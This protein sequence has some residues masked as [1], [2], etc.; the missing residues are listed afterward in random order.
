MWTACARGAVISAS[1]PE[2]IKS[3]S[4]LNWAVTKDAVSSS[5][6]GASFTL[7]FS[8]TR[9]VALQVDVSAFV[10]LPPGRCPVVAWTINGGPRQMHQLRATELTLLLADNVLDPQ[11]DFYLMG[12]SPFEDRYNGDSPVNS[13][14]ITGFTVDPGGRAT[15]ASKPRKLWLSIGDSILAGDVAME[16]VG[17]GRP[18]DDAWAASDDARACY[19]YLLAQHYGYAESRLA[20]GGYDYGGG[21]ANVPAL[22]VLLDQITSTVS[23]LQDGRWPVAPDVVLVNL[24]ENGEPSLGSVTDALAKLRLRAGPTARLIVMVPLSGKGRAEVTTAVNTYRD[25]HHD[26]GVR[27]VDPGAIRYETADG[28]HP[29]ANGHRAICNAVTTAMDAA[30]R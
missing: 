15:A 7:A 8:G 2:V 17:Q 29:T 5:V 22:T 10:T 16:H 20:F 28:Q 13:V 18:A 27:L 4:A 11:I 24:G 14:R 23:R 19:G 26:S 6:G 12:F 9:H 3:L 1:N 25:S 30:L 21:L